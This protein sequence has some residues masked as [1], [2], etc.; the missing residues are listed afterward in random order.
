MGPSG[1]GKS[2]L[3]DII[4]GRRP[5]S[6]GVVNIKIN[7]AGSFDSLN[8]AWKNHCG[9]IHQDEALHEHLTVR[10]HLQFSLQLKLAQTSPPSQLTDKENKVV[11]RLIKQ[12][13]LTKVADRQV[14][15][16][17]KRGISGGERRR[18]AIGLEL[19]TEP[20]VLLVGRHKYV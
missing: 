13:R 8:P 15:S 16:P 3:L 5:P 4:A 11:N 10:E 9:Y 20:S 17:L 12:L 2:T 14:G 1:C 19:V 6:N 7:E 18:L